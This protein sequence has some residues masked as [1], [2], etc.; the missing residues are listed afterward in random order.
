MTGGQLAG[1]YAGSDIVVTTASEQSSFTGDFTVDFGGEAKGVLG[2]SPLPRAGLGDFVWE[3]LNANGIQDP[4]ELDEGINGVQVKLLADTDGDGQIDDLVAT[5]FTSNNPNTNLPGYYE[6][7]NLTPTIEYVVMFNNPDPD[8]P[9]AYMFS[10]F[11]A[12][13]NPASGINSDGPMSESRDAGP[14]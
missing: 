4:D 2:A 6:F 11:Q 1:L 12:D 14:R 5:T 9:D 3:D 7:T 8:G 13:G 10:P